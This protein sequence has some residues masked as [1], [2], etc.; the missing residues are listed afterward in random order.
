MAKYGITADDYHRMFAEQNGCCAI[1]GKPE[2]MIDHRY[3]KLRRL[4]VDHDHKTGKVRGLLCY[5]HNQMV[6]LANDD[7]SILIAGAQYLKGD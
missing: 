2:T 3:G 6:G 4:A 5:L 7:P 1:C